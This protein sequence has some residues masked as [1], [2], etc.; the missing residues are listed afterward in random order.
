MGKVSK[1]VPCSVEGCEAPAVKSVSHEEVSRAG[2]S[3]RGPGRAYLCR[4]HWKQFKRL[5]KRE[6]LLRRWAR[7]G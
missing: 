3:L 5:T 4:E 2:I 7:G 6:R 1:G